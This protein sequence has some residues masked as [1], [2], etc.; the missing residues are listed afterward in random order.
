MF[1]SIKTGLKCLLQGALVALATVAYAGEELVS[2]E[3]V[4]NAAQHRSAQA[5]GSLLDSAT[6]VMNFQAK[7]MDGLA[8]SPEPKLAD[9]L[10][11]AMKQLGADSHYSMQQRMDSMMG[12]LP[13]SGDSKQRIIGTDERQRIYDTRQTPYK[14]I[15]RIEQRFPNGTNWIGTAEFVHPRVLLTNSHNVYNSSRGG[16][17]T[18]M[19]VIPGRNGTQEPYGSQWAARFACPPEWINGQ[20]NNR[21][22]DMA[23]IILPDRTLFNRIGFHFGYQT[24]DDTTLR[25][26]KLNMSGYH[27]DKN[28]EQW[29]QYAGGNQVVYASQF[30]HYLDTTGGSSGSPMWLYFS[31]NGQRR[32]V[33]VN[34]AESTGTTAYNVATRMTSRYFGWTQNF[35]TQYP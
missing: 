31:S 15:C 5:K 3:M 12:N 29:F 25:T 8:M 16:W 14:A 4:L 6:S 30:R 23:W 33:G 35:N 34:C 11:L 32:V 7:P 26:S 13:P 2:D 24:T 28:G 9:R 17:A 22:F 1:M 19:R 18:Q 27:G 10:N 20:E 21:D